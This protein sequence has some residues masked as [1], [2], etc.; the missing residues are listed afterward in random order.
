MNKSIHFFTHHQDWIWWE[1]VNLMSKKIT[2]F[3]SNLHFLI[4]GEAEH[5]SP[6]VWVIGT[7]SFRTRTTCSWLLSISPLGFFHFFLKQISL[8]VLNINFTVGC[9]P[10]R[11]D[12]GDNLRPSCLRCQHPVLWYLAQRREAETPDKP[13]RSSAVSPTSIL[14]TALGHLPPRPSGICSPGL[15]VPLASTCPSNSPPRFSPRVLLQS[16]P[17]VFSPFRNPYSLFLFKISLSVFRHLNR[18][19]YKS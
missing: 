5:L 1:L 4:T 11:N 12:F 14:M 3:C 16:E 19:L 9:A 7:S 8:Y 13:I 10:S 6:C 18:E 17:I 15:L 2:S